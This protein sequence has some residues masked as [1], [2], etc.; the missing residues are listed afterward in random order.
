M[1]QNGG[2]GHA[3]LATLSFFACL[4]SFSKGSIG[5]I[6]IQTSDPALRLEVKKGWQDNLG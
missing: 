3:R 5:F 2:S 4:I 1:P 6:V